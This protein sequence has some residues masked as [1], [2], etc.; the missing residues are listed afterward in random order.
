MKNQ[1]RYS[2]GFYRAAALTVFVPCLF[3]FFFYRVAAQSSR[4][5]NTKAVF[6]YNITGFVEWPNGALGNSDTPFVIGI[7]GNDPF[8]SAIDKAVAS[9]KVKGHPIVVQRFQSVRDLK[10]CNLL[11]ISNTESGTLKE[12]LAA[13]PAKNILTVSDIPDF[14]TSGGIIGFVAKENKIKLQINL[15]ASKE[16][17]LNISSKL[18][19]LAEI[20][21]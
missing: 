17:D 1:K 12:I 10:A 18:L 13:L 9:E 19:H 11:F 3:M 2:N 8:Q 14:A 21:R 4:E 20:V 16:A 5:Y 7:L 15:A 6:L